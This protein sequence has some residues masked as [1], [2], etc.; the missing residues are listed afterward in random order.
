LSFHTVESLALEG[1][2]TCGTEVD[3]TV[4]EELGCT[5]NGCLLEKGETPLE[6]FIPSCITSLQL[7]CVS[8]AMAAQQSVN[9]AHCK[10]SLRQGELIC[11]T[12]STWHGHLGRTYVL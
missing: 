9:I 4:G 11:C 6:M 12:L 8:F 3:A 1:I 7:E 10:L 5:S 2:V